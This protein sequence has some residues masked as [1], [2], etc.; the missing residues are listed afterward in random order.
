M[1]LFA[2]IIIFI[3]S[4]EGKALAFDARSPEWL[5][6]GHYRPRLF[7]D[8]QSSI[9]SDNFFL[10]PQGKNSPEAELEATIVLFQNEG[11]ND[12]KC[13]FP[14]RYK[15]LQ[16]NGVSLKPYPKCEELEQFYADLQPAGVTL[17]FTDAFM[18]NPASLFG[19]SLIRIDTK[20]KGTQLLA[21]GVNYGAFTNGEENGALYALLGLTGGYFGGFTIKPYYDIINTYNNIENRDIWE[22]NLNFSPEELDFFVAHLWEV[23]NSLTRYYFFSK[24][25]SYM[26]MEILDAVRPGLRLAD[27]FPLQ[28]IPL[29]TV[30]AVYHSPNLVKEANYRPSRQAKIEHKYKQ[31]SKP[32]K[33]AYLKAIKN[34]DYSFDGLSDEQKAGVLETTYQFVQYQYVAE[35][36]DLQTYRRRSFALLKQRSNLKAQDTLGELREGKSPLKAHDS[37]RAVLGFG[38]RNGQ[39]FQEIAYRP[40]YHSLTDDNF[41]F[42]RGAE[43]NFLNAAFRHYDNDDNF[44]LQKLDIVGVRTISPMNEM[45]QP[46]SYQI[47]ADISREFNPNNEKDVY[48]FNF[49]AGGGAAYELVEDALSVYAM[50]NAYLAYG[51]GLPHNQWAGIGLAA[52]VYADFGRLRL[53]G[54]AEKVFATSHF[55]D[56][57]KYK[58]EAAVTLSSDWAL[59]ADYI[60]QQNY[61]HDLEEAMISLRYYF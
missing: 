52:G 38:S 1:R 5:A 37:M 17:L 14:A 55:A 12:K 11:Q 40:A 46:L 51:G 7:G 49:V 56:K 35:D 19:H 9:D 36:I 29:D 41:G 57:M 22:L 20:R 47:K 15:L 33:K 54:E 48:V 58:L 3:C 10:S 60:Y 4:L 23:G 21:H 43:I 24:N 39:G 32:Q 6:L 53:L 50:N 61:G 18:N 28:A 27:K 16:K 25:C 44:V 8:Y 13:L 45:F 34:E 26:L 59:A 2:F 31:M 42:R 30:K